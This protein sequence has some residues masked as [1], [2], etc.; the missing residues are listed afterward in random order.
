MPRTT[1]GRWWRARA[2]VTEHDPGCARLKETKS[3]GT[4]T[5]AAVMVA[6]G[7]FMSRIMGLI[8]QRV[9]AHYLGTSAA[10]DAFSAAMRIPNVLQNLFGEGV[11]SASFI[12]IYAGL[13]ARDDREEATKL[14]GAVGAILALTMS[15]LVALG[16]LFT[17]SLITVIAPGFEGETRELS[18]R[19]VR[20][21]FPGI[22]LLVLSA[23]CLGI[24]NSHRR[25]FLSYTAP[26]VWNLAIIT[27][28]LWYG[29]R[30]S[31]PDLAVITAW[32]AVAGSA[33]QFL[34]QLPLVLRLL[35]RLRPAINTASTHLRAVVRGFGPVFVG[36]GVVQI[37]GYI[38]AM[39]ASLVTAG[40]VAALNSAQVIYMLPVSLFGMSVSAAE[41]PEMSSATGDED[42]IASYLRQ[43]LD[44]GLRRIAFFVIPSAAGLIAF[45]DVIAG[46]LYQSGSFG[47]DEAI[48]VWAILA[49]SG[50]GLTASTLGRLYA[51]T[52]YALR[53]TRTPL[54]FALL[55]VGLNLLL[56]AGAALLLPRA[57]GIDARWGVAGI[58]L[59]SSAAGWVEFYMLRRTL[60]ARIG[61]PPV[62]VRIV[63]WLWTGAIAATATGWWLRFLVGPD[64]PVIRALIIL[65]AFSLVYLGITLYGGIPEA[66]GLVRRARGFLRR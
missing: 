44:A 58:A 24:L 46:L 18:I 17:P 2:R 56:G 35:G 36:R 15:V 55:R 30:R 45:G 14:A 54:R 42:T 3:T 19:L 53:D 26:V 63:L 31:M 61:A 40:A 8:R 9:F 1:S 33:L 23:W 41:L 37:S 13:L 29:P 11:L 32:A 5:G 47:R 50:V 34:V 6:L 62:P 12:P 16:V 27:A 21:L 10:A 22:G 28:L 66:R 4:G 64:H 7:I 60:R 43:R 38:D 48:W 20:I 52:F 39:L 59:A 25:F 49:G 51:S 65:G 57:L